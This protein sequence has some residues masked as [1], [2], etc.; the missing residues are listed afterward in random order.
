MESPLKIGPN[1][2]KLKDYKLIELPLIFG[3]SFLIIAAVLLFYL[4]LFELFNIKNKK[5]VETITIEEPSTYRKKRKG[6]EKTYYYI[7]SDQ[8]RQCPFCKSRDIFSG[9]WAPETCRNCKATYFFGTW[10][11]DKDKGGEINEEIKQ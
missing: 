3:I 1:F 9:S 6:E 7:H 5:T 2:T 8:T 10:F 4:F 11:L